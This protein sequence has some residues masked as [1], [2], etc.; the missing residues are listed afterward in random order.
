[1]R[2]RIAALRESST[3]L[4]FTETILHSNKIFFKGLACYHIHK[5]EQIL[6][7]WILVSEWGGERFEMRSGV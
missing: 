7:V 5:P 3:S 1:M 6:L 2:A 4:S